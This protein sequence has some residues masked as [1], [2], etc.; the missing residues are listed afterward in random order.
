MG[1]SGSE[2]D[3]VNAIPILIVDDD[4]ED[5]QFIKRAFAKNKVDN[6][7]FTVFSGEEAIEFLHRCNRNV[8]PYPGLILLDLNMPGVGGMETLRQIRAKEDWRHIPIIIF[9][10]SKAHEDVVQSYT[11]GANSFVSKPF[12]LD[13]LVK[14]VAKI[15]DFWFQVAALPESIQEY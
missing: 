5:V 11:L 7:L 15:S 6:P 1:I 14:V 4:V 13:E 2:V 12:S 10:T 8:A 9:T 3:V